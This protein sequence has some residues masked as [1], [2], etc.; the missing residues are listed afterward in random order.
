MSEDRT[1]TKIAALLRQAEGTDN[2]HEADAFM[3]AAQRL[4]TAASID[5]AVARAHTAE[6]E[7]PT[8]PI[9]RSIRIGE[10]GTRGL[11]TYVELFLAIGRAND[12]TSDIASNSSTVYCYGFE[13]DIA[14]CEAL[15]ASLAVQMVRASDG[16]IKSGAYRVE[17]VGRLV[18]EREPWGPERRWVEAP[19]RATTARINFQQAYAHRIG[20][21]LKE[22]R[23][24]TR[25]EAVDRDAVTPAGSTST[26]LALRGKQLELRD[27][28]KSHSK[29]RGTWK[30][31]RAQAGHSSH[32][33]M[34]GDLAAQQARIGAEQEIGGTRTALGPGDGI[35]L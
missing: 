17:K 14:T 35:A 8:V 19:V 28:Y 29:A 18:T 7:K 15:Y 9:Q 22:A 12:V 3:Q 25:Q 26:E 33:R 6:Q 27:F 34:S 16:Y 4:A 32:A 20:A 21:R 1:L 5:L 10:P 11:R 24:Q 31:F 30:G 13:N 23:E 2:Q